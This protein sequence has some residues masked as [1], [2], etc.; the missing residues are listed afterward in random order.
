MKTNRRRFIQIAGAAI[1]GAAAA[2]LV[3]AQSVARP[4]VFFRPQTVI[5]P[6]DL[7]TNAAYGKWAVRAD[8]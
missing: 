7:Y 5:L 6:S 1:V 2:P 3:K 8:Q 4:Q